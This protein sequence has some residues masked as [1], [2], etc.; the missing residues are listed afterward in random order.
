MRIQNQITYIVSTKYPIFEL[1]AASDTSLFLI[2]LN[3]KLQQKVVKVMF[4]LRRMQG[5]HVIF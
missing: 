1:E 3:Q 5:K 4:N 2:R